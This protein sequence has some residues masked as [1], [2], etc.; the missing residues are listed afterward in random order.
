M[1]VPQYASQTFPPPTL[2]TRSAKALATTFRNVRIES[3]LW[4][5]RGQLILAEYGEHSHV[6]ANMV[7]DH[8]C[9]LKALVAAEND[10]SRITF[11]E[12]R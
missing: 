2:Q 8:A 12:Q 9:L 7:I 11:E 10:G 6:P 5:R 1:P 4:A 3:C